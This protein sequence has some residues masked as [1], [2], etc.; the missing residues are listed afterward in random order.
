[1][2]PIPKAVVAVLLPREHLPF[3][4]Q[5]CRHHTDLG[6]KVFLYDNSGSQ[7]SLRATSS[8]QSGKFQR[9]NIDKRGNRYGDYTAEMTDEEV[10][11]AFEKEVSGLD[12]E[13]IAWQP[14]D[15][16]GR[17]VHGQVEAYV[18]FIHFHGDQ[19]RW[20]AFIDADE[21]LQSGNGLSWDHLLNE[22]ES[23]GCHRLMI[24]G[25]VYESRWTPDG[26]A[27]LLEN[28]KC[29]GRQ[30]A[31]QKNIVRPSMV[32]LADIHWGW[33]MEG[34]NRY[35]TVD[36]VQFHF[37]HYKGSSAEPC[38]T[39]HPHPPLAAEAE[40]LPARSAG[41]TPD[42][43][44]QV[45]AHQPIS[46]WRI[47]NELEIYLKTELRGM[48]N[49]PRKILELG[50]GY[51]TSVLLELFPGSTIISVEHDENWFK[52]QLD[53]LGLCPNL[54]LV[55][56]P[57]H[58]ETCW[59]TLCPEDYRQIDVLLVDGPPGWVAP[60][61]RAGA[62]LLLPSLSPGAVVILNN[63]DRR[64]EAAAVEIW[65]RMGLKLLASRVGFTV[66]QLPIAS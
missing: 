21:Y 50:P 63:T 12:V 24:E 5:W 49:E 66:L 40:S 38:L 37:K 28:L 7:G 1:M 31:G 44:S 26:K 13:I 9:Q 8:F 47:S 36:S 59:Y 30:V 51:S 3:I 6:W 48:A 65:Q 42:R 19:F 55:L 11:L 29:C 18:D 25:I 58:Q 56:A 34:T 15:A 20:A 23:R 33:R 4:R 62:T 27:T 16:A 2:S 32:L 14:K 60:R 54:E 64:D 43:M 41:D 17:I 57:L 52:R 45:V 35:A 22:V 10:R 53:Q 61:V 46:A 39:V